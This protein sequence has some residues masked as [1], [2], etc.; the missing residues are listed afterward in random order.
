M[1]IKALFER[2][3]RHVRP[4]AAERP[5]AAAA[6]E[7]V[8]AAAPAAPARMATRFSASTR[9]DTYAI[10][11][12]VGRPEALRRPTHDDDFVLSE[13]ADEW[14]FGLP[15]ALRPEWT[16]LL[17]PRIANRIARCW[18]D[19]D[20]LDALFDD[21]LNDRRGNRGGLPPQ[22]HDEL[23]RLDRHRRREAPASTPA[24]AA[25]ANRALPAEAIDILL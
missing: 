3:V 4:V 14:V 18:R 23:V 22:V 13:A 6:I 11:P 15:A 21:L 17:F 16:V 24:A 10:G 7:A 5:A 1:K 8:R 2:F 25:P 20:M 9:A 12:D 19:A